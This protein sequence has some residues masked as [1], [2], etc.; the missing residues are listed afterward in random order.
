MAAVSEILVGSV[1]QTIKRFQFGELFVGAIIVGI[2][3]NAAEHGSSILLARRGKIDLSIGIAA[4]SASQIALFVLPI[5]VIA[6]VIMGQHFTLVFTT[7]ELV[8]MFLSVI[9]LNLITFS[10][11]SNWFQGLML[12][13][14][15]AAVAL[16]FY[17]IR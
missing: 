15:Y 10:G 1:E 8:T 7:F 13:A 3:N 9:I 6:G 17:F 5:I 11:K 4:S 2:A 16:G 14:L 12:T